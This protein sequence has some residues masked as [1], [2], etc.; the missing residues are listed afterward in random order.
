MIYAKDYGEAVVSISLDDDAYGQ[1]WHVPHAPAITQQQM[2]DLIF[3]ELG[4]ETKVRAMPNIL[5]SVLAIFSKQLKEVKEMKY[6]FEEIYLVD[7]TKYE[8]KFD[9]DI[10]PHEIAIKETLEWYKSNFV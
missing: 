3:A 4:T 7:T 5:L 1:I 9:R 6:E 8:A 2:A 10:T